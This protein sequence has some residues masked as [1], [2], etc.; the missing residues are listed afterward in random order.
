MSE[1]IKIQPNL[2]PKPKNAAVISPPLLDRKIDEIT[3]G[4]AASCAKNLRLLSNQENI[5][6][7]IEYIQALKI[8]TSLSD[9]YKKD[10]IELLT[11]FSNFHDGKLFKDITRDDFTAFLDS[12]RKPETV[13][14]CING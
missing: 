12:F 13:D 3:A 1:T 4:L 11:R 5:F 10:N 2:K 6:T 14:L 7:I 9:H 8:E